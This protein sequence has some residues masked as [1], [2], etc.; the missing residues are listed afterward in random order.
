MSHICPISTCQYPGYVRQMGVNVPLWCVCLCVC[1]CVC[2]F[3][4][5]GMS[6]V[7]VRGSFIHFHEA[8]DRAEC[9][10]C[11]LCVFSPPGHHPSPIIAIFSY[12]KQTVVTQL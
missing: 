3:V 5:T 9:S 10:P 2:V 7:R 4:F 1:V 8:E 11:P 12:K 6:C